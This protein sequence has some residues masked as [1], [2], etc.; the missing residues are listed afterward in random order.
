MPVTSDLGRYAIVPEW[1]LDTDVSANAIRLW[2]VLA[3]KFADRESDV[4][5]PS[6][7]R[8]ATDL[9]KSI[10]TVDRAVR[11]LVE[12]G[13]LAVQARFDDEGDPTSNAYYLRF[14]RPGSRTDAQSPTGMGAQSGG[15]NDAA[16]IQ[17]HSD[18]ES[19][20]PEVSG[21]GSIRAACRLVEQALGMLSPQAIEWVTHEIGRG[22]TE[23]EI[24][25]ALD[26]ARKRGALNVRYCE[27]VL[28]SREPGFLAAM[29]RSK[30]TP[31]MG[32]SAS[33]TFKPASSYDDVEAHL[34][35]RA[36]L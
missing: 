17:N 25:Y 28:R 13:A 21:G 2:A 19:S 10:D 27:G 4:A 6:R 31:Q 36:G 32:D 11:E 22:F 33:W 24:A 30:A 7:A 14:S 9:H 26:E 8:L 16:L 5:Y 29:P 12:C 18:P 34:A 35:R 23:A 15:G 3:A 20:D 1:L